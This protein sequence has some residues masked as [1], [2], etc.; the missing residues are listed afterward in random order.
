[1]IAV[2]NTFWR[3]QPQHGTD[4]DGILGSRLLSSP[5]EMIAKIRRLDGIVI[6]TWD[7]DDEQGRVHGLGIVRE[8]NDGSALVEWCRVQFILRPSAQGATQWKNRPFF[9]FAELVA[10]RY[11]LADY[12]REAFAASGSHTGSPAPAEVPT[13]QRI[14]PQRDVPVK[15]MSRSPQRNRVSPNGDIIATPERGTFMGNRT[16]PPRWL[17]CDLHFQRDLRE[18]RKYA[19]LFFLDE[20]VA[21]A[22]GHRPCAT[23][24]RDC[25]KAY[26]RAVTA[27]AIVSG[28]GELD[29]MLGIARS[30]PRPRV[31]LA[32]LPDGAFVALADD[33]FRLKWRGSLHRW[34]PA[35]YIQPA[36]PATLGIGEAAV[37]TP[38]P[39]LIA[40]RNGYAAAVH[41]SAG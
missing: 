20:A 26:L 11:G 16:S 41:P 39:S 21:L 9:K 23:C 24:R 4:P 36:T 6:G 2:N 25:Y 34:T 15:P 1:V 14:N 38:E 12:F 3:L 30:Q 40:L 37:L 29:A 13:A 35:G 8:V 31:S 33:D 5:S 28:A 32:S 19:K 18:Q 27:G 22:A 7:P 10:A 17:I